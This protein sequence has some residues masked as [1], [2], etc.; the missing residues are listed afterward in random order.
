[1]RALPLLLALLLPAAPA[2]ARTLA[3]GPGAPYPTLAAA[4]AAAREGDVI[5]IGPG[6]V[7]GC[8]IWRA[9]RLT[10][11]GAG[12]AATRIRGPACAG[13][14]LFVT[15]GHDITVRDLALIGATVADHNGAGIRA[16]GANL[17]VE[18][19]R[20]EDDE[21]GILAAANPAST[22]IVRD[23][24]FLRDGACIGACAHG[25]YANRV[26]RLLVERTRFAA[27][28]QGHHVKSRA[29]ATDITDCDIADGPDGTASY[30]IDIPNGGAVAILR[31][32]LEKGPRTE[33][34]SSAIM[35]G[36]EG[37]KN[38]TPAITVAGNDF[39]N[40]SGAATVFVRNRTATPAA[41]GGNT[42]TGPVTPLAGPGT[43]Q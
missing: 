43:V 34:R 28:R 36:E 8:A 39:R 42:L 1:M 6:D 20:F 5:A 26:A 3:V 13:K 22:L 9:N 33:N 25:L 18:R 16:E 7:A 38:P 35:I 30:L 31:N 14:G 24:V 11:A 32:R 27:T 4:A 10:I 12:M 40:E 2:S 29:L 21:N 15:T 37:E 17:T 23:S 41:L 19:V